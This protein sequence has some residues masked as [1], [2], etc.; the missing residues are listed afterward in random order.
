[1]NPLTL[2]MSMRWEKSFLLIAKKKGD[3]YAG[4]PYVY[5]HQY[6]QWELI[7][8]IP[9]SQQRISWYFRL[10]SP[11][12][13]PA[14]HLVTSDSLCS[15]D[16]QSTLEDQDDTCDED[17]WSV[18]ISSPQPSVTRRFTRS[19]S[20]SLYSSDTIS[21][22]S[23]RPEHSDDDDEDEEPLGTDAASEDTCNI[24]GK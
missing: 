2:T 3:H 20:S 10:T 14:R 17:E 18:P 23:S 13:N 1:M 8:F 5:K 12:G 4:Q 19:N 16:T 22:T 6:L 21:T 9:I 15:T 24:Q 11:H 7:S